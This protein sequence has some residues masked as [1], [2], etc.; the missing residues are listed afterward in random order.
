MAGYYPTSKYGQGTKP[1][2]VSPSTRKGKASVAGAT[3][4]TVSSSNMPSSVSGVNL[5]TTHGNHHVAHRL[6]GL[7]NHGPGQKPSGNT[8]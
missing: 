8:A 7:K 4:K 6:S 5:G 3:A 1:G 2:S